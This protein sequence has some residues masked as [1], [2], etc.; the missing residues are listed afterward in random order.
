MFLFLMLADNY[1]PIWEYVKRPESIVDP[2]VLTNCVFLSLT[3]RAFP[4][5]RTAEAL[6]RAGS[7]LSDLRQEKF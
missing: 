4:N 7:K 1:I 2:S 3:G 5:P 6:D